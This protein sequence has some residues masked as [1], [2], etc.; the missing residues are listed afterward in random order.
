MDIRGRLLRRF[1]RQ[2]AIAG[3]RSEAHFLE[4]HLQ[5]RNALVDGDLGDP[6]GFLLE[7]VGFESR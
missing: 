6:A 5:R 4:H 2:L 1:E 7:S 3:G